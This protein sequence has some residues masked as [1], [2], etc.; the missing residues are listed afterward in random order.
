MRTVLVMVGCLCA[1]GCVVGCSEGDSG[2]AAGAGQ[3]SEDGAV[4]EAGAEAPK[5]KLDVL[6]VID[7]SASMC[8]EQRS[9]AAGIQGF[10]KGLSAIEG[11]DLQMAVVTVQQAQGKLDHLVPGRFN[12]TAATAFPPNCLERVKMPCLSDAQCSAAHS[13][14]FPSKLCAEQTVQVPPAAVDSAGKAIGKWF[15]QRPPSTKLVANLNCSV[16]SEC[17]SRCDP[18][19]GNADCEAVFGA[20]AL[21]KIPGG[22]TN[23]DD[24][25]CIFPPDTKGCAAPDKLA[26]IVTQDTL[27]TFRCVATVGASQTPESHFEGGFRTAFMA[28]DPKGPSCDYDACVKALRAC[29]VSGEPWCAN[30][31]HAGK[32]DKFTASTCSQLKAGGGAACQA[33]TLLRDNAK[34]LLVFISDDDDCSMKLEFNPLDKKHVTK[35]V[36]GSCQTRGDEIGGNAALNEGYCLYKQQLATKAY[37]KALTPEQKAKIAEVHCAADC[38]TGSLS[39]THTGL[40]KCPKGCKADSAEQKACMAKVEADRGKYVRKSGVFG[41]V[42]YWAAKLKTLKANPD[43]VLFAAV[44]GDSPATDTELRDHERAL[45]YHAMFKD[46]GPGQAPHICM[47]VRGEAN[48]GSRYVEMA[49]AFGQRGSFTSVCGPLSLSPVLEAIGAKAAE[50]MTL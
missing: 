42:D 7:Q 3:P 49:A 31:K 11:L 26:P 21:C 17:Q 9:L 18:A 13:Y 50:A 47:G 43:D 5:N 35:E 33:E 30:D 12:T 45:Y 29:C 44:S 22:G 14:T 40:F 39:K 36:R 1:I 8:Q 34:L 23:K 10:I 27:Q 48:F 37:D 28:L 16:N 32:C 46:N 20:G 19:K 6:W 2:A 38:R 41:S 15:C 24:A 25:A 4:G